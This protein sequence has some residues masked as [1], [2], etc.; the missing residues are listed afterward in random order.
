[1]FKGVKKLLQ[2]SSFLVYERIDEN[3]NIS[4][5]NGY[6]KIGY[7]IKEFFENKNIYKNIT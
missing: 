2:N 5:K 6:N 1:M 7:E 4:N 3:I